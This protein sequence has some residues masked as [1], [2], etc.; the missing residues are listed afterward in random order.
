MQEVADNITVKE[1]YHNKIVSN[2]EQSKR[3]KLIF[4]GAILIVIILIIVFGSGKSNPSP[5]A[6]DKAVTQNEVEILTKKL[7]DLTALRETQKNILETADKSKTDIQ[8]QISNEN[9]LQNTEDQ[10]EGTKRELARAYYLLGNTAEAESLL[11]D[12]VQKD[13][14]NPQYYVDLGLVYQSENNLQKA[15]EMFKKAVELN[16]KEYPDPSFANIPIEVYKKEYAKQFP[17]LVY[18]LPTP[19]S[20]LATLYVNQGKLDEAIAVLKKGI[21]VL[22]S[23]PDFYLSLKNIYMSKGMTEEASIY[24]IKYGELVNTPVPQRTK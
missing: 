1:E 22:P 8:T 12:V 4:G 7:N 9:N 3:T 11:Q 24:E 14:K 17:P 21:E 20:N 19:Y 13:E 2:M 15:E 23:Y 18:K 6:R 16:T 10:I 5:E